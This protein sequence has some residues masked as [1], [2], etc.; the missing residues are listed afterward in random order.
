MSENSYW[1]VDQDRPIEEQTMAAMCEKCHDEDHP[2]L[3]WFWPGASKGYGPYDIIC[4]FCK[5]V[6]HQG[7]KE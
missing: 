6:I 1:F 4:L 7:K 5:K 2:D 3:G